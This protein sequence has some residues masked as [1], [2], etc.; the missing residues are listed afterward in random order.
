[1]TG[2]ASEI[3]RREAVDRAIYRAGKREKGGPGAEKLKL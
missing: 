3:N 2:S 1:M